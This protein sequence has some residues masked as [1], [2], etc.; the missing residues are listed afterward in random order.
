MPKIRSL[1]ESAEKATQGHNPTAAA[2]Y[3]LIL[4]LF[5]HHKLTDLSASGDG[6]LASAPSKAWH[7]SYSRSSVPAKL[8][9]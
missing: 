6:P 8:L 9:V 3:E 7:V 1:I 4:Y 5:E 2:A